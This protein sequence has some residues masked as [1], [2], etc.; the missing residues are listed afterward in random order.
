MYPR[1]IPP[2]A[3]FGLMKNSLLS[4]I[5]MNQPM[6]TSTPRS[7]ITGNNQMA[8]AAKRHIDDVSRSGDTSL[9]QP[10]LAQRILQ[11]S[12][13]HSHDTPKKLKTSSNNGHMQNGGTKGLNNTHEELSANVAVIQQNGQNSRNFVCGMLL[14][15]HTTPICPVHDLIQDSDRR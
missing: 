10:Q 12:N 6:N 4:S 2:F 5:T 3:Q 15:I 1:R 13:T 8:Q 11:R 9:I 14:R 7:Y